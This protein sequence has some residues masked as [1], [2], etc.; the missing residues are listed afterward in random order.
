MS[1]SVFIDKIDNLYEFLNQIQDKS[2]LQLISN[3]KYSLINNKLNNIFP[4]NNF[5]LSLINNILNDKIIYYFGDRNREFLI[6]YIIMNNNHSLIKIPSNINMFVNL[7]YLDLSDN[8]IKKIPPAVYS[9]VNLVYL[10]LSINYIKRISKQIINLKNLI[11]LDVFSAN[12]IKFPSNF[13]KLNKIKYVHC[14]TKTYEIFNINNI[15]TVCKIF[16]NKSIYD[17]FIKIIYL[18]FLIFKNFQIIK[19]IYYFFYFSAGD[20]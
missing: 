13:K 8:N 2:K 17:E 9:L 3:S 4:N 12:I 7:I 5:I 16:I 1:N 15:K 20:I 11:C 18:K 10:N 6:E 19:N 14:Q